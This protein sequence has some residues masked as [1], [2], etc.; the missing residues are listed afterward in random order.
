MVA[1]ALLP[2]PLVATTE[3]V[4]WTPSVNPVTVQFSVLAEAVQVAPPGDA[5]TVYP[6]IEEPK[7]PVGAVHP[8]LTVVLP[9][10][11]VNPVGGLGTVPTTK[12]T[13]EIAWFLSNAESVES[14]YSVCTPTWSALM[15]TDPVHVLP[16]PWVAL[17]QLV[18]LS[19]AN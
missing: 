18:W 8:T 11:T 14:T 4:Y 16:V 3:N 12:V 13:A 7:S 10:V 15:S 2:A 17:T 1:G 6:V 9:G 5:V 19:T